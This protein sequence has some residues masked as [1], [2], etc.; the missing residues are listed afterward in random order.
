MHHFYMTSYC[1]CCAEEVNSNCSPMTKQCW[2]LPLKDHTSVFTYFS[3]YTNIMYS[4]IQFYTVHCYIFYVLFWQ[5]LRSI[6]LTAETCMS[7]LCFTFEKHSSCSSHLSSKFTFSKSEKYSE[8]W[9]NHALFYW[10]WP[11][12]W[13]LDHLLAFSGTFNHIS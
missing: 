6:H 10:I 3:L 8:Q 7:W 5:P 4:S 9:G 13:T 12:I 1:M 11:N 2:H